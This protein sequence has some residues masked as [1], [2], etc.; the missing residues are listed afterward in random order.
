MGQSARPKSWLQKLAFAPPT[1][2]RWRRGARALHARTE[3]RLSDV[4][5]RYGATFLAQ[6]ETIDLTALPAFIQSGRKKPSDRDLTL[7]GAVMDT[8]LGL[9]G[10]SVPS[11]D[12]L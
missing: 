12:V 1:L 8:H 2:G 5:K 3:R 6:M 9:A 4:R 7:I 10:F 11:T